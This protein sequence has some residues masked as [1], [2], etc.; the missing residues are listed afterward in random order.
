MADSRI[1]VDAHQHYWELWRFEYSWH[2]QQ[3]EPRYNRDYMPEEHLPQMQ[4][5]GIRYSVV[6]QA[7]FSI[8]ETL[9]LLELKQRYPHIAGVV[10]WVDL[11]APDSPE[12]IARLAPQEG[13]K[14]IRPLP[15]PAPD[16]DWTILQPGLRA[17]AVHGLACDLLIDGTLLPKTIELIR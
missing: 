7:D 4:A 12:A 5:T 1:T 3:N 10:G 2:K 9:W 8:E 16:G 15:L 6:I 11:A 17:L 13:L 14:S